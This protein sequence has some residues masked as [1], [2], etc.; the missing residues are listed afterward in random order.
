MLCLTALALQASAAVEWSHAGIVRRALRLLADTGAKLELSLLVSA[1]DVGVDKHDDQLVSFAFARLEPA[2]AAVTAIDGGTLLAVLNTAA[3]TRSKALAQAAWEHICNRA[4]ST[5]TPP[6]PGLYAALAAARAACGDVEA[7]FAALVEAHKTHPEMTQNPSTWTAVIRACCGG[8]AAL[9][10][11][12]FILERLK[13]SGLAVPV[14]ALNVVVAACG[15]SGDIQRAFETYEAFE[16]T[17]G[18]SPN[19]DT[20]HLLMDACTWNGRAGSVEQLQ[21]VLKQLGLT[22][23][24]FTTSRLVDADI[25]Q[26]RV[27]S[28]SSRAEAQPP[29]EMLTRQTLRRLHAAL[30]EDRNDISKWTTWRASMAAADVKL[31]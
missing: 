16:P 21:D 1:I 7:A 17:F 31:N 30:S 26:R 15:L 18:V 12:Y 27:A 23:T 24:S 3:R 29:G 9:D 11:A 14:A 6:A 25:G 5:G 19:L 4:Q 10:G 13:N 2:T 28:A 22:P 8:P 20:I